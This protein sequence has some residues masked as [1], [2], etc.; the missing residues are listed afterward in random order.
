MG[1]KSSKQRF[2][3]VVRKERYR[4]NNETLLKLLMEERGFDDC[5]V[6]DRKMG[7]KISGTVDEVLRIT[8]KLWRVK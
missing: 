7:I 5:Y 3:I 8:S 1:K 2:K 6:K 4:T